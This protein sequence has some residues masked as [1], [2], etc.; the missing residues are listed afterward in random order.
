MSILM[1]REI[2]GLKKSLLALGAEVEENVNKAVLSLETRDL[3]LA[4]RVIE[5]DYSVDRAEV[6]LEEDCLKIL[7]LHQPVAIDLRFVIAVLKINN[8]LERIGDLAVN[9]AERSLFLSTQEP[10]T[11]HFDL[12]QMA[13]KTKNMLKQSL[14][15]LVNMDPRSAKEVCALDDEVDGMNREM[16]DQVKLGV[17]EQPQ[18]VES[19]IHMLSVSRHLERIADLS[20]NIAEDVIYMVAG[21]IVR[22]QTEN[23]RVK[24][25]DH[26]Q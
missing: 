14:A 26:G 23:F 4:E 22:H 25:A 6:N 15:S 18:S 3:Q 21:E 1:Q 13:E 17:I 9:I 19:L 5:S 7:A 2:E 12:P 16:Y 8:D 20:T 11:I 10:I 24:S